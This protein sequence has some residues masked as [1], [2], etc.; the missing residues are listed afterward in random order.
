MCRRPSQDGGTP[1]AP[2]GLGLRMPLLIISPYAKPGFSFRE[3]ANQGSVARFVERVFGWET[4]L[5]DLDPA[6]RDAEAN[7]LLGAF[8]FDEEPLPPLLPP[9]RSC[10]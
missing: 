5:A 4:T 7:D 2:Y 10:P 6:A 8:D 3:A 1:E 9:E